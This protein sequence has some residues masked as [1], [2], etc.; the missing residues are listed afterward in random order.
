MLGSHFIRW[1]LG[2]DPWQTRD[3]ME[4]TSPSTLAISDWISEMR[5]LVIKETCEQICPVGCLYH[6]LS[7]SEKLSPR[8]AMKWIRNPQGTMVRVLSWGQNLWHKKGRSVGNGDDGTPN[9]D[10]YGWLTKGDTLDPYLMNML[11]E[12]TR[13]VLTKRSQKHVQIM[14]FVAQE[15][16][17]ENEFSCRENWSTYG[18]LLKLNSS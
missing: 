18:F 16:K 5:K 8:I 15:K 13:Q 3:K 1:R 11:I 9:E 2:G 7:K 4:W 14:P 12:L 17:V 6:T 10:K